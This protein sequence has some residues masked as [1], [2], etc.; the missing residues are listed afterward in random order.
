MKSRHYYQMSGVTA[1]IWVFA[2]GQVWGDAGMDLTG[3]TLVFVNLNLD[4]WII[5]PL[6]VVA[7]IFSIVMGLIAGLTLF[8]GFG[9]WAQEEA[10]EQE[11]ANA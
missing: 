7:R 11:Q 3:Y 2:M 1:A 10:Q 8:L 5:G 9:R 4:H 6:A